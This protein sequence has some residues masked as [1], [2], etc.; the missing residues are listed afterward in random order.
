VI[1]REEIIKQV[2]E[3][4]PSDERDRDNHINRSFLFAVADFST[5]LMKQDRLRKD[6]V[7]VAQDDREL[8]LTGA[9]YDIE[10]I[11][12]LLYGT[13]NDQRVLEYADQDRFFKDYNN[14]E[15][16]AGTPTYFT[17]IGLNDAGEIQ[18]R[19]DC[20]AASATTM[21]VW[22]YMEMDDQMIRET[23]APTLLN[24][25]LA[26]FWGTGSKEG[27][28][29]H[30]M[31]TGLINKAKAN[32]KRVRDNEC[33]FVPSRFDTNIANIRQARRDSR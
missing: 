27:L 23:E 15:A 17:F 19:L 8:T 11:Y 24:F 21:D 6:T 4:L 9:D 20:P 22:Y 16:D 10:S 12:Y 28:V 32:A 14:S 33:G 26:Y 3:T 31:G 13:G 30:R 1:S 2:K 25:T 5:R 29:Y 18:I 7:S